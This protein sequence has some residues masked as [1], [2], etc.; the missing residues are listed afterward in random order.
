VYGGSDNQED[1][2]VVVDANVS[3][4]SGCIFRVTAIE[5]DKSYPLPFSIS[6]ILTSHEGTLIPP[7]KSPD[8]FTVVPV[9]FD[10]SRW[11]SI[12]ETAQSSTWR[13]RA[14]CMTIIHRNRECL[15]GK[16]YI[17]SDNKNLVSNWKDTES[18]TAALCSAF[19]TYIAHVSSAIHV[20]R[21]H[22]LLQWVDNSARSLTL[23]ALTVK[24]TFTDTGVAGQCTKKVRPDQQDDLSE[25]NAE[26]DEFDQ[27]HEVITH[28]DNNNSDK[29][30]RVGGHLLAD[31][32]DLLDKQH[33]IRENNQIF[34]T[35]KF[36]GKVDVHSLLVL[37]D[38]AF[39][40]LKSIHY[41]FGH[42]TVMGIRKI[43][44]LWRLWVINFGRIVASIIADC[45][46]CL[47]CRENFHPERSSIPMVTHPMEMVMADFL[48]PEKDIQPGFIIF[49]DRYSGFLEGRAIEKLDSFEVLAKKGSY[50]S[51][52]SARRDLESQC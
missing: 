49:K 24:R 39:S 10:G 35:E 8:D 20:K 31:I 2:L 32:S 17:I 4:W 19:S 45:P 6:G 18:L 14:A 33:L 50:V 47:H 23:S 37:V 30:E 12:F 43:L 36:P 46:F 51:G 13:E 27:S 52:R 11:N 7:D 1:T 15:S 22:P 48:Q 40:V 44:R 5:K 34:T 9:R 25:I 42:P 3:G 26:P 21:N 28:V 29:A 41:D 38:D 16:V